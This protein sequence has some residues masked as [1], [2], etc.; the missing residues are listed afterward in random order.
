M[1]HRGSIN[2]DVLNNMGKKKQNTSILVNVIN[3]AITFPRNLSV[4]ICH[5]G[6]TD[7]IVSKIQSKLSALNNTCNP[8]IIWSV[9]DWHTMEHLQVP[10]CG[11]CQSEINKEIA[12]ADYVIFIVNERIGHYMLREW[13]YCMERQRRK[14]VFL[15]LKKDVMKDKI[16]SKHIH[17]LL[18]PYAY[19]KPEVYSK[20]SDIIDVMKSAIPAIHITSSA[21]KA[22]GALGRLHPSVVKKLEV[23]LSNKLDNLTKLGLSSNSDSLK[24]RILRLEE[25]SR[26]NTILR[27]SVRITSPQIP[28]PNILVTKNKDI[29]LENRHENK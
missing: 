6:D 22:K 28:N 15:F 25:T 16:K 9:R 18:N 7:D 20:I 24:V 17:D 8:L 19:V 29:S 3:S 14:K 27:G 12:K 11:D 21:S 1:A 23:K 26:I 2:L 10:N 13:F 5:S 4:F